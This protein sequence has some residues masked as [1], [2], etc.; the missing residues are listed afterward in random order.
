MFLQHKVAKVAQQVDH[1]WGTVA[2]THIAKMDHQYTF[3]I[4]DEMDN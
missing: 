1:K 3:F 2:G 4:A